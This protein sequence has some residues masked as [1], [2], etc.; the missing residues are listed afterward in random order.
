MPNTCCDGCGADTRH[1]SGLCGRC[2]GQARL[3]EDRRR[4][5]LA[6]GVDDLYDELDAGPVLLS[7]D[8]YD[9]ESGPNEYVEPINGKPRLVRLVKRGN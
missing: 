8:P 7:E 1:K 5:R 3:A 6:D 2:R 9:E 4:Y